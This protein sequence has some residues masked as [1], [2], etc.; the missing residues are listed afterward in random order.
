MQLPAASLL[1]SV[2]LAFAPLAG[3][4]ARRAV[5]LEI[6]ESQSEVTARQTQAQ[7]DEQQEEEI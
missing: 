7:A 6:D 5:A 3:P 1:H 4:H 2:N